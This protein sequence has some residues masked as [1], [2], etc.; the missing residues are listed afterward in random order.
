MSGPGTDRPEADPSDTEERPESAR[1]WIHWLWNTDKTS[2]AMTR[3]FLLSVSI[4]IVIVMLLFATTGVWPPLVAVESD[5]ME[6]Q[7]MTGDLVIIVEPDRF[8]NDAA[9]PNTGVVPAEYAE[10]VG[11]ERFDR[12]GDVIIFA[13]N[14]DRD[15][16]PIIHRAIF[17]VEEGEDWIERADPEHL[18][19]ASS[20]EEITNCPA[21]NAGFITHGDNNGIYDQ[22]RGDSKPVKPEWVNARAQYRVPWI[23]N[24]RLFLGEFFGMTQP[25]TIR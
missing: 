12:Y 19:G 11:Y 16:T 24:F 22:V 17:W 23:G 9:V 1:E 14:G 7:I 3:D 10:D 5:S 8:S 20:C 13:P 2:V 25:I 15:R 4:V 6:D 21:P 18:G